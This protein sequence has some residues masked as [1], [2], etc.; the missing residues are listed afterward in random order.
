M[1]VVFLLASV[2]NLAL[3]AAVVDSITIAVRQVNQ[4]VCLRCSALNVTSDGR[5][6][7]TDTGKPHQRLSAAVVENNGP[8]FAVCRYMDTHPRIRYNLDRWQVV[9]GCLLSGR[10]MPA[11]SLPMERRSI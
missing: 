4:Q 5:D 3:D 10:L 8:R 9:S 11:V 7:T 2:P 6:S 1:L